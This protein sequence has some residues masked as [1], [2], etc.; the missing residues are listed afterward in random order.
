MIQK[1]HRRIAIITG[2][3]DLQTGRERLRGYEQ[4]LHEAGIPVEK[5]RIFEGDFR[6]DSGYGLGRQIL[7]QQGDALTE[8]F[9]SLNSS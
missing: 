2:S 9:L 6:H 1:G 4:A 5:S 7:T 8:Q 3:L